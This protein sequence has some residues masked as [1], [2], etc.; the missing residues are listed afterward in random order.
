MET[1]CACTNQAIQL[2]VK[3]IVKKTVKQLNQYEFELETRWWR[4]N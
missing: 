2:Y 4:K 3:K 1:V